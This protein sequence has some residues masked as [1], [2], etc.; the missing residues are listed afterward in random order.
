MLTKL[1]NEVWLNV[2]KQIFRV[3][4]ES[5]KITERELHKAKAE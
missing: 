2:A 3:D 5:S 1:D 4:P